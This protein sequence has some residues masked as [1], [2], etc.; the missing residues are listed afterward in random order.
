MFGIVQDLE[1]FFNST[2]AFH[3]HGVLRE[4]IKCVLQLKHI[5]SCVYL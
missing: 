1:I 4:H 2:R 3:K 5:E